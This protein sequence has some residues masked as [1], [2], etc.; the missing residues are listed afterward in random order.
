ME[1]H[2]ELYVDVITNHSAAQKKRFLVVEDESDIANL[3]AMHLSDLDAVVAVEPDGRSA[4]NK[5]LAEN[6]DAIILDLQLPGMNGLDICRAIRAQANFIP[7]LMLTSRD[8]ELDRVLGLELGAD[9]YL[10]KPFSIPELKAR[11]KALV[12]RSQQQLL[13]AEEPEQISLHGLTLNRLSR[14]VRLFDSDVELTAKEFE[15]LWFF[16]SS[17]GVVFNRAELLDKVWGYGHDGYEHTVNSHINRLRGKL[18]VDSERPSFIQTIWG[19]GYR[20]E[21]A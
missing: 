20:F 5:A 4:L 6:W 9:D 7:I 1:N 16:A 10:A 13:S 2:Q 18:E 3:V 19:V 17:P 21:T 15:L 14:H 11:V 12:R 8:S